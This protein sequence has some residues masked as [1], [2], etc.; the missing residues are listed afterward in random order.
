[1]SEPVRPWVDLLV[2]AVDRISTTVEGMHTAIARPWFRFA[3]PAEGHLLGLH[4]QVT[5]GVYRSVRTVAR[6]AGR[7]SD[8]VPPAARTVPDAP[9]DAVRAFANAVWGD[10]LARQRSSMATG[11]TVRA[12]HGVTIPLDRASVAEAFPAPTDR[13]VVLL[14]GLG[15][16]ERCFT[17]SDTSPGLAAAIEA[18]ASTPVLV[19]YNSGHSVAVNGGELADLLD[20]LIEH[21]PV[22]VKEVALVGYSMGGLVARAAIHSGRANGARWTEV[23]RHLVTIAAPHAGSPIEKAVE[24]ASRSLMVAPQ[25]RPLAGFLRSRSAGIRDL[26]SGLDLPSSFDGVEHHVVAAV[27]TSNAGSTVGSVLGDLV[28]RPSSAVGRMDLL[29]D[30][31]A[32][33]GGRRHFDILDDPT[34]IDRVL[35]WLEPARADDGQSVTAAAQP[36]APVALGLSATATASPSAIDSASR[37]DRLTGN[38]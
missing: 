34:V 16:T 36:P 12:R 31:E 4:T 7:V 21:W 20:E 6:S 35:D 32:V 38:T 26:R 18:S 25:T 2:L 5:A 13:I 10:D 19:R 37:T 24:A 17:S 8:L 28:V 15:Q 3:G 23:V 1:L 27:V 29:V 30:D 9:A 14:H 11:M 33:I 22:P